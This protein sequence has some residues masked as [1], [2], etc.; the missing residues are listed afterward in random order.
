MPRAIATAL[1]LGA[2]MSVWTLRASARAA[3]TAAVKDPQFLADAA[4][5]QIDIGAATGEEVAAF[6]ARV[7]AIPPA[8]VE[9]AKAALR[10]D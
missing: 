5:T 3:F 9:R 6:I 1:G 7:W 8:V 4:K 2:A 10:T